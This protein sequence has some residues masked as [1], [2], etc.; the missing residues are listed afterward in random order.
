MSTLQRSRWSALGAVGGLA[1]TVLLMGLVLGVRPASWISAT[2]SSSSN[3]V[4]ANRV[5]AVKLTTVAEFPIGTF[6]EDLI[7]REDGSMLVTDLHKRQ[8]WYL[9]APTTGAEVK[10]VLV[11]TF[12]QP[13]FDIQEAERDVFYIDAAAYLT[14]HESFLYRV[15]LRGW[16]P[17]MPASVQNVLKFPFPYSSVNG[18]C[19]LAPN[20]L[21]V[22]DSELGLI[23][24]VDLSGDGVKA[25][26]SV[27]LRDAS[28][29]PNPFDYF[30]QH[31]VQP[32]VN[33]LEYAEKT[34]F[35]YYTASASRLFMRVQVDPKTLQ[36]VGEP[37]R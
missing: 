1:L 5:P 12:D 32:G 23:W 15:D 19:F 25:S 8:L 4:A 31:K 34:H 26:A 7:V 20:V 18:S 27:W 9:P 37:E 21:L 14:S 29:N 3:A 6:L 36:P 17:G 35:L 28:M 30:V 2:F 16:V 24:R 33:G 13:A 10:P 11:Y 22:A